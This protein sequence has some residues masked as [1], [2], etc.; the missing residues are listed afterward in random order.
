MRPDWTHCAL[1]RGL[2]TEGSGRDR[3]PGADTAARPRAER[4][5]RPFLSEREELSGRRSCRSLAA[6][7]RPRRPI[8]RYICVCHCVHVSVLY[9]VLSC[10]KRRQSAVGGRKDAAPSRE[11]RSVGICCL[12]CFT[13]VSKLFD[14]LLISAGAP[15]PRLL[16]LSSSDTSQMVC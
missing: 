7:A 2:S 13:C 14:G 10:F 15:V 8:L 12:R 1:C 4:P 3:P 6:G 9:S 11:R 16:I 5:V